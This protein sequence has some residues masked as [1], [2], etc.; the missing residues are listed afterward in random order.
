MKITEPQCCDRTARCGFTIVEAVMVM[1]ILAIFGMIAVPR[2]AGFVANQQ[3]EGAARRLTADLSLAQRQ[4]R[5]SSASQTVT[6]DV[7]QSRYSLVGMNHPDHPDQP[8]EIRVG[9]EPYRARIVSASFGVDTQLVYD[10]FGTPDSGGQVVI[11]VG[12]Y[13]QTISVDTGTGRPS[14]TGG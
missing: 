3:L 9:D 5:R 2:Y 6:F 8:F 4:A 11:A 10:G 1:V 13:Q 12:A 14:K 7:A